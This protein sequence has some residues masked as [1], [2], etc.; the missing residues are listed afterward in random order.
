MQNNKN[1][2]HNCN[3]TFTSELYLHECET[4]QNEIREAVKTV[5][6]SLE[7]DNAHTIAAL[8][9]WHFNGVVDKAVDLKMLK[10][11]KAAQLEIFGTN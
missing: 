8:I 1:T 11:Y 10:G 2:C 5:L 9:N 7:W 6:A 3:A 4:C